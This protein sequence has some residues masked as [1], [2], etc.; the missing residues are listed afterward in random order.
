[1]R[2]AGIEPR[3]APDGI[4]PLVGYRTWTLSVAAKRWILRSLNGQIAHEVNIDDLSGRRDD[5]WLVARCGFGLD[6]DAP[7]EDCSC[8]FYAVKSLTTLEPLLRFGM[9][10]QAVPGM[11]TYWV[12]GRVHLAGKI[13][14]HEAG[15]RAE[16]LRIAE[17]LAFHGTEKI[18]ARFARSLRVPLGDP[19]F[20]PDPP[21]PYA[22][23]A[24]PPVY[25]HFTEREVVVLHM[26]A[27]GAGGTEI[28]NRLHISPNTVRTH[29]QHILQKSHGAPLLGAAA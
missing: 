4:T 7:D 17:F 2:K 10:G 28:T 19:I 3:P 23:P 15:Y 11:G 26:L 16:R 27:E 8:G 13:V 5:A 9:A 21:P 25:A 20:E 22:E 24:P 1:M 12:A 14:E 29:I 18:V 6:H